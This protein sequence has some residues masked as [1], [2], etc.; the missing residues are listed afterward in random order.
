MQESKAAVRALNSIQVKWNLLILFQILIISL[1]ASFLFHQIL[2]AFSINAMLYSIPFLIVLSFIMAVVLKPG[3]IKSK[4]VGQLLDRQFEQLEDS[5]HLLFESDKFTAVAK[6]Q[7]E[8][9]IPLFDNLPTKVK[10]PVN[11]KVPLIVAG[12]LLL[13]SFLPGAFQNSKTNPPIL[14]QTSVVAPNEHSGEIES[15]RITNSQISIVP[16]SYTGL[17]P[18]IQEDFHLEIPSGS[19][20]SWQL[21]FNMPI[22]TANLVWGLDNFNPMHIKG[23]SYIVETIISSSGFYS[24]AITSNNDTLKTEFYRVDVI[25]DLPPKILTI[26]N[27]LYQ[28][29]SFNAKIIIPVEAA[30]SDDYGLS[31]AYLVTTVSKGAGEGVKFREIKIP[32]AEKITGKKR[33]NLSATMDGSKLELEPGSELY[34]FIE[35]WDN[36]SPNPNRSRTETFFLVIEDTS[37]TEFS[38]FGGLAVDLMPDYFRSQRQIIIETEKL[39][40]DNPKLPIRNFK[41][42]SNELGFDQK[43]LRLKYSQFLGEE[44][45]SG[46]ELESDETPASDEALRILE[47]SHEHDEELNPD[48]EEDPLEQVSHAHDTEE[49]VTFFSI[50]V[51][52]KLRAALV[53]M[54]DAELYLRLYQPE[55][56]LPYQYRALELI[57]EIKN[58]ARIYVQRVGFDPPP[59]TEEKRLSG[60]QEEVDPRQTASINEVRAEFPN[61]RLVTTVL[62][63][64]ILSNRDLTENEK[65]LLVACGNEIAYLVETN[66]LQYLDIL[67]EI[68]RISES[69][70]QVGTQLKKLKSEFYEILISQSREPGSKAIPQDPLKANYFKSGRNF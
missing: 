18:A 56:S 7:R 15:I 68:K 9:I 11:F 43:V 31:D 5:S 35:A 48:A 6:I 69:D 25:P 59:L 19:K 12:V 2:N 57:M 55:K 32:F 53:E 24:L 21:E 4:Q 13:S 64:A 22:E 14:T 1:P 3:K 54:W 52:S 41:T 63:N 70:T 8:K 66:P 17:K 39:I 58:H 27:E 67:Q 47:E 30:I 40:K 20:V 44:F 16:P 36:K 33:V 38:G 23:Q 42:I 50:S 10:I 65:L 46:I 29:L 28:R 34:Y 37:S 62:D 60:K 26:Q 49:E 61:I 45:L 51:E